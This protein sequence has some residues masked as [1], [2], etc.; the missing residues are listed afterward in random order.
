MCCSNLTDQSEVIEKQ[1]KV[2]RKLASDLQI[3]ALGSWWSTL[4]SWL[5]VGLIG[6][7]IQYAVILVA[8]LISGCCLV[9]CLFSLMNNITLPKRMSVLAERK[10]TAQVMAMWNYDNIQTSDPSITG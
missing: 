3:G 1:I 7:I 5:P 6:T 4:W 2:L 8:V 10:A 9:Q